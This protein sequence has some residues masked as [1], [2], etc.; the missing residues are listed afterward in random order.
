MHDELGPACRLVLDGEIGAMGLHDALHDRQAESRAAGTLAAAAPE[1]LEDAFAVVGSNTS[2]V[3]NDTHGARVVNDHLHVGAARRVVE[4]VLDEIADGTAHHVCVASNPHRVLCPAQADGLLL[5]EGQR[6]D[7]LDDLCACRAQVGE[8]AW[9]DHERVEFC[10]IQHLADHA[11]H[12]VDVAQQGASLGGVEQGFDARAQDRER[13]TQFMGGI[14]S[15]LYRTSRLREV[16]LLGAV[17]REATT[18][19]TAMRKSDRT[20]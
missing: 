17:S 5:L 8:L 6:R 13:R 11:A 2:T 10:R 12:A 14:E 16:A 20:G 1:A 18:A 4:R 9:V 19:I 7:R 3:V 15:K